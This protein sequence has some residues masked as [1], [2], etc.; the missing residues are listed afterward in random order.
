MRYFFP[1]VDVRKFNT[2]FSL[3]FESLYYYLSWLSIVYE[4]AGVLLHV[5][6]GDFGFSLGVSV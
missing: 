6:D 5:I 4:G 2:V 3:W 1:T